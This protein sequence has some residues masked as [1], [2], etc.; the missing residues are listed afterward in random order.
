MAW[1]ARK[2]DGLAAATMLAVFGVSASQ[3]QAFM[4]AYLQRLGGQLDEARRMLRDLT[5]GPLA[6]ALQP[7][8]QQAVRTYAL[9]R[10]GDLQSAYSA[11]ATANLFEK[12]FALLRHLDGALASAAL[13][14]FRPSVPVDGASV[15]YIGAALVLG[16]LFYE[17]L[18]SPIALARLVAARNR[19]RRASVRHGTTAEQ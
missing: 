18:K 12:P 8:A 1:L 17:T 4:H 14:D 15:A 5:D 10:I 16:W 6:A 3:T 7:E 19:R 9:E 2:I 11:I 13:R